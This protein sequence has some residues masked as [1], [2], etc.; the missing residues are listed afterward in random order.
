[1]AVTTSLDSK[2]TQYGVYGLPTQRV[3]AHARDLLLL[4]KEH[5]FGR[6]TTHRCDQLHFPRTVYR[7][8]EPQL[9]SEPSMQS[10]STLIRSYRDGGQLAALARETVAT[11]QA[12]QVPRLHR[13]LHAELEAEGEQQE[14]EQAQHGA[15]A[16]ATVAAAGGRQAAAA[17]AAVQRV[18]TGRV[19]APLLL[20]RTG[21]G[22]HAAAASSRC[23]TGEEEGKTSSRSGGNG[24]LAAGR[25]AVRF[26]VEI[27][28]AK[29]RRTSVHLVH[30]TIGKKGKKCGRSSRSAHQ[31][32]VARTARVMSS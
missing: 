24:R 25:T 4:A 5:F 16:E 10:A 14:A 26:A 18:P 27:R 22:T 15:E 19:P 6:S 11:N 17:A 9:R 31:R 12:P 13:R 32:H 23:E 1:M 7:Q 21:G 29:G 2:P 20:Q 28:M 8:M 30:Y 3:A